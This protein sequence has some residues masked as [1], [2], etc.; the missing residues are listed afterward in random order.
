MNDIDFIIPWVNG[1]DPKIKSKR[2]KYFSSTS[3]K[4]QLQTIEFKSAVRWEDFNE[5]QLALWSIEKN[6]PWIRKIWIVTD[7]QAP[8]LSEF[9]SFVKNKIEIIDH[10]E[11]FKGYEEYLPTFNS[12][13]IEAMTWRI[14]GLAEHAVLSNDDIFFV[15]NTDPSYFFCDD[16]PVFRGKFTN[17]ILEPGLMWSH[18]RVN[19]ALLAGFSQNDML[20]LGHICQPIKT[21]I[22]KMFFKNNEDAL[23]KNA[24]HRTRHQSQFTLS[25]LMA[26]LAL[27]ENIGIVNTKRDWHFVPASL[28]ERG[29]VQ[30]IAQSFKAF[31]LPGIQL[32]NV[33]NMKAACEK[34]PF[35]YDFI[36]NMILT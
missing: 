26:H 7:D 5:I 2:E 6:A 29:S 22:L 36:K 30:Q 25:S 23:R 34:I 21:S 11:I 31:E 32:G 20:A 9:S 3:A 8:N 16:K 1:D 33:N 15:K 35:A 10:K 4:S 13:S 14:P 17:G 18:H 19:G 28:C 27:R 12:A 24:T